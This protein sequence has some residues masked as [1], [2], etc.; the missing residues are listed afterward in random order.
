MSITPIVFQF[1][2][3]DSAQRAFD[4]LKELGYEPSYHQ[5][6]TTPV[7][8]IHVEKEDL[9]SALEIGHACNGNLVETGEETTFLMETA[10]ELGSIP[11][12][13]HLINEDGDVPDQEEDRDAVSYF[14]AGIRM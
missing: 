12:P 8:H 10:Y 4:T 2:N 7:L 5:G 6:G 9:T 14:D 11:I 1:P 3:M 13:A